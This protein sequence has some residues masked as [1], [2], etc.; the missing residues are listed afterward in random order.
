MTSAAPEGPAGT[1]PPRARPA[2]PAK[3]L[4]RRPGPD[5]AARVF[6]FPYA[7]VGASMYTLWPERIGGAELL[8]VQLPGREARLR[9]P[10]FGTYEE[11]AG[12]LVDALAPHLDR[13]FVF[14]GHCSGVLPAVEAVRE[15]ER[16]GLRLPDRLVVSSQVA[17]HDGPYGR[18]LD[19]GE[20]ELAGELAALARAAGGEP[21][22]DL[23][24]L[25]VSVLAAD[26]E[27][28]RR[29]RVDAPFPLPTALT[30]VGWRGDEV[31]PPALMGGW[32]A[33]VPEDALRE[34][35]LDGAHYDFLKAPAPLVEVLA[36]DLAPL[37]P[38]TETTA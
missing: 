30:S 35:L 27:A 38:G 20:D 26:I 11:L 22:P 7:G 28:N 37:A 34:V 18:L 25:G 5:A 2:R 21:H 23:I 1:A 24:E 12:P 4:L 9:E 15:L 19:L 16:R 29:Y 31:I 17:P 33:Y 6:L 14:F 3:W 36:H 10:H 32:S 8:P 13:P